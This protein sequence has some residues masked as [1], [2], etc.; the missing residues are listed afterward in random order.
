[1]TYQESSE[2]ART[3]TE[4]VHQFA[5][6]ITVYGTPILLAILTILLVWG[7]F[8]RGFYVGLRSL[9][10]ALLPIV[11]CSSLFVFKKE[12]L[13]RLVAIPTVVGLLLGLGMGVVAMVAVLR[14]AG[15]H[16]IPVA[17][18]L[19]SACFS[20]LVFPSAASSEERGLSFYYGTLMGMLLYIVIFG[21]PLLA[22]KGA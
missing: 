10:A 15:N 16:V 1:M 20:V 19:V 11:V 2:A 3:K 4:G 8:A 9:S 14:L 13:Q 17:E 12:A 21:F 7:A 6:V 5:H 18:L 22:G